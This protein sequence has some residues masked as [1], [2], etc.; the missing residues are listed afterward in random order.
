[1]G[2]TPLASISASGPCEFG[3]TAKTM[4]DN[5]VRAGTAAIGRAGGL[6]NGG[7][8]ETVKGNRPKNGTQTVDLEFR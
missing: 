8:D 4:A 6:W 2:V 1:M 3:D 7:G 5:G